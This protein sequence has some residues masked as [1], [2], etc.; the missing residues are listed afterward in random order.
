M[1]HHLYLVCTKVSL[2]FVHIL[3]YYK[4]TI[5]IAVDAR[6]EH[7]I[8]MSHVHLSSNWKHLVTYGLISEENLWW[9]VSEIICHYG[10]YVTGARVTIQ[11]EYTIVLLFKKCTNS[12]K[13]NVPQLPINVLGVLFDVLRIKYL[14]LVINGNVFLLMFDFR[15]IQ[16]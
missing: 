14:L 11:T 16:K 8:N 3:I 4:Y 13:E 1:I 6:F 12:A 9:S 5:N 10:E 7:W 15:L 2:L